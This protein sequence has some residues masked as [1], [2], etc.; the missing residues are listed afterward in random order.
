MLSSHFLKNLKQNFWIITLLCGLTFLVTGSYFHQ[1]FPYTHDGENHLARFANYKIAVKEQQ[2]PPRFAPNLMNHYGYPVFNYNYPL[3]NILSLPFSALKLNY[4]FTFKII[5]T[6]GIGLGLF[7]MFLWLRRLSF[8]RNS[9][10]LGVVSAAT[11]PY[12]ISLV[13]F[14]GNIGEI[15]AWAIFPWLLYFLTPSQKISLSARKFPLLI[16]WLERSLPVLFFTAFLLAHNVSVLFGMPTLAIYAVALNW[17]SKLELKNKLLWVLLATSLTLWFWLPA[18]LEKSL[19]ILDDANLSSDFINHFPSLRQLLFSPTEFGFSSPGQIDSLGISIG[20][21]FVLAII[22]SL[23]YLFKRFLVH[24][25][26]PDQLDQKMAVILSF[27]LVL[28]CLQFAS[29]SA[30]WNHIPLVRFIQFP[31]RLTFFITLLAPALVA[32]TFKNSPAIIRGILLIILATQL[33]VVSRIKP[34]DY[35]HKN[36]VD[37]D[38][39]SQSTTTLNENTPKQFK[40]HSFSAQWNPTAEA[41][42]GDAEISEVVFW[43]GSKH[44]YKVDSLSPS[45][46]VEPTMNFAGWKTEVT[47]PETNQ[48]EKIEY[49]DD[50]LVAGRIA[51]QLKPGKYS[52]KTTFTQSTPARLVGNLSFLVGLALLTIY[53]CK[54]DE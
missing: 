51:Y 20:V 28:I 50:Q 39:F 38:A 36:I 43:N 37:Y 2:I 3:A 30:L 10:L 1:G 33:I 8:D 24:K 31:W 27:V 11:A 21:G 19:V 46:I 15:L 47:N 35:F 52:I 44:I 13:A 29:T 23:I 9:A 48:S 53:M 32:W 45:I 42:V 4:E 40:Y 26:R 7:G 6:S 16:T 49:Y 25:Q 54:S 22:F 18:V 12:L 14:R 17:N 5:A 41:L 34:V